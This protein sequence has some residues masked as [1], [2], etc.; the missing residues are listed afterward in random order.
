MNRFTKLSGFFA[1]VLLFGA[2]CGGS[3]PPPAPTVAVA[4]VIRGAMTVTREGQ[5]TR[6]NDRVRVEQEATVATGADGRGSIR[7]DSGAFILLDRVTSTSVQLAEA[8]LETGRIWVDTSNA[9][10]T[11]I[12][13]AQGSLA[14][15][16][17]T[18]A[19]SIVE[20]RTQV[21][22]GN[23]EVTY[24]TSRGDGRLQQGERLTLAEGTEPTPEPED[25]WDDWTGGLADPTPRQFH[26]PAAVGILAGRQLNERGVARLP[27]PVRG[28]EVTV[29]VQGDMAT[30]NVVQTFFNAR[31]DM[32]EAEYT[33]RLPE[34]SIVSG[35]AVDLGNGFNEAVINAWGTTSGYD[36]SWADEDTLSSAL[37]YD[38][39]GRLRARLYPVSPGATVR[40]R[41]S[42]TEWL[43]R[44]GDMRTYVYPMGSGGEP[45][46]LGEF[47]L[48][49]D[50]TSASSRAV[51]AG[52][53]AQVESNRVVLR[54][55]DF[56]PRTDFYLDLIDD[57]SQADRE[58][59]AMAYVVDAPTEETSERPAEGTERYV[60]F[61]IPTPTGEEQETEP[62][63]E[64]VL[65]VDVSGATD[66]EDLELAR[67]AVEAILRQL[68]PTDRVALLMSD[69]TAHPP[70]GAEAELRAVGQSEREAILESL[71]RA[72]LGGA[73]DL[74]RSLRDAATLVSGRPRGAVLYLGDA[75]PT[76]G[77]L[78]AT[79]LRAAL[80]TITAPPRFFALGIGDGANMRLLQS[81]FGEQATVVRE[82]TE[83]SRAV[84][85]TLAEAARPT[86]RGVAV[87]LGA[88]V[89]RV[90]PR[91][92]ITL[93]AGA[94][95]RL[96]GRLLGDLPE[97]IRL[98]GHVD[99]QQ[100]ESTY[101]VQQGNVTDQGDIRRRWAVARLGELIDNDSGREA[102]VELGVRFDIVTPWTSLVVGSSRGQVCSPVRGF[103]Y[104]P[105]TFTWAGGP[106]LTSSIISGEAR[107]WRRNARNVAGW[108]MSTPESTWVS[109]VGDPDDGARENR[110]D[111]EGLARASV[112][113]ALRL[114][115]RG[116][117]GCYE[118]R[119][120]VRN[121][122]SGSLSVNVEV[123][124]TGRV[125][126]VDVA[127]STLRDPEVESCIETEV[128]GLRFPSTGVTITVGHDYLFEVSVR[129]IGVRSQCSAASRQ[130][131]EV[132]RRLWRERLTGAAG[133]RGSLNVWRRASERCELR[134]W[135]DQRTL[136][137]LMLRH[138]RTVPQQV[139][140]HQAFGHGS[141]VASYLS[142]AILRNV[143]TPDDVD[144]VRV[145]LGLEAPVNWDYFSSQWHR[146]T[147]PDAR[148]RIVRRWL[149][150]VP[151]EMDLRLR[152]LSL[153]EETDGNAEARR[154]AHELR[155]DPFADARVRTAV[156]E[157]W[158]RQ[159]NVLEAR[160]V[161]SELI[162]YAPLDPWARRRLG[163]LY[164]T[165]GWH[166]DAYREYLTLARLR[167]DDPSV[168]LL[169]A[170]AAAGAGRM[171]EALR[172]EQEISESVPPSVYQGSAAFA[173]LWTTVRLTRLKAETEDA[174]MRA[175]IAQRERATGALRDPPALFV[176][177]TWEHPDDRPELWMRYPDMPDDHWDQAPLRG[178][179]FGIEA[180][181]IRERESGEYLFEIRRLERDELRD[182]EA[183]LLIVIAPGTADEQILEQDL[184]LTRETRTL[185][186][187]L[188][189]AG[190]LEA[191]PVR[192]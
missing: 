157:F 104:D 59:A 146:N 83:A 191:V 30:T 42:Y 76:T 149:E 187:R 111:E 70:E 49:V 62:P 120:L 88:T 91:P 150:A 174:S 139:R 26:H 112:G 64:L 89:E 52:M 86:L 140:L 90:Y 12:T 144:V 65:L 68:T 115:E 16:G 117:R 74:G 33:I 158:L 73:T 13:T 18:F 189:D 106:A 133:V 36:L 15:E 9:G 102:L 154:L 143:R 127:R 185:R 21:Y 151:E 39:P 138:L 48:E 8:T 128:R 24:R 80:S 78:D 94:N 5:E 126:D 60:L 44:R 87:Q 61:D 14:A 159:D 47:T 110:D 28:H 124:G 142:R 3:M 186:F 50:L 119:L 178:Q 11:T 129:E 169:L 85:E 130:R 1:L 72:E 98:S 2:A 162:E 134:T 155:A 81:L 192:G 71:S 19:V 166:E 82:R 180:I 165:H 167:P 45:P 46:L 77:A 41:L 114:G 69:V 93:S 22:C 170:R 29:A 54:R 135:R 6:V 56:R 182:I 175:S 32:L 4:D 67:A 20:N 43:D 122:L 173:R 103:D 152:L 108:P 118:R 63:L 95:L 31:S 17:A 27:L 168:I 176:A 37:S 136:L 51:R 53:G 132:R 137:D 58:G 172:L 25:L 101:Q 116:P 107:G 190:A 99:G 153:L 148:L 131:L 188:D 105:L 40:V 75:I 79:A 66:P 147:T 171:D 160:R 100:V 145:G 141:P 10:E 183:K 113:R 177:V 179:P 38:G 109:R 55:S 84:M 7:L 57:E 161:F 181:R 125:R 164:R 34:D 96:V 123:D 23:G 97:E 35:F 121:D 92:P 156:G 163:D 184:T